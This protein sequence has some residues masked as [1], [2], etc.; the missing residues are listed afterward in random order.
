M[1]ADEVEENFEFDALIIPGGYAPDRLRRYEA[2][3]RLVKR[4]FEE[5]KVVATICHGGSVLI[6]AEVLKGRTMTCFMAIKDDISMRVCGSGCA[7]S[8]GWKP[9]YLEVAR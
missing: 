5:N 2:V 7:C 1:N 6:S 9:D 3:L 8:E 4:A